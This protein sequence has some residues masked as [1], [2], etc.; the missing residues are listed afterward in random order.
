MM[1]QHTYL[2][3]PVE[4]GDGLV[5]RIGTGREGV[6]N[7]ASYAA[8]VSAARLGDVL[9][10]WKF[11]AEISQKKAEELAFLVPPSKL[12]ICSSASFGTLELS[13]DYVTRL[14]VEDVRK[15][16]CRG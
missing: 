1:G 11:N 3:V 12:M 5:C 13:H 10:V 6:T 14:E 2:I 7:A 16:A 4:H 9:A 8:V 15:A